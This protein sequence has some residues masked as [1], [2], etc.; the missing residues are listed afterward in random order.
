MPTRCRTI[1]SKHKLAMLGGVVAALT[2]LGMPSSAEAQ[3]QSVKLVTPRLFGYFVGDVVQAVVEVRVDKGTEFVP[4]SLPQRGSLNQWLG[5]V[6][7]N[8]EKVDERKADL[9]R[10]RFA[11]QNFY[12][13]L[14]VRPLE[15]P[16]FALSFKSGDRN[17]SA[18]V[19]AWSFT[20]APL[21]E[22]LPAAKESGA[23]YMQPDVL[24]AYY[25]ARRDAYITL[26]LF[27][28]ALAALALLAYHL[29]WWPFRARKHRPF[30]EAART[31]S[32]LLK[33]TEDVGPAY[34]EALVILHRAVDATAGH[35]VFSQDVPVFVAQHPAFGPLK[36]KLQ[37]F[38]ASSQ[39]V[40]FG[41]RSADAI[42]G[43]SPA[44]LRRFGYELAAA[45]RSAL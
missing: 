32:K 4:A 16:A 36:D 35:A 13:A 12:P 23:D 45:E 42:A 19:P 28:A 11:Y 1:C 20:I 33:K 40:F 37:R 34:R 9:Y 26:G 17:Y 2:F 25:D 15:V 10:F 6:R 41:D 30:T 5:L 27:A 22:V 7:S 24:P 43:L 29:A 3:V 18:D 39:N 44:E 21:R 8:V 38:F 31:V 14:D